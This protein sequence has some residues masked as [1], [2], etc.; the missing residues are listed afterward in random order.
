M[1]DVLYYLDDLRQHY[2]LFHKFFID[3]ILD[4]NMSV[5]IFNVL[6]DWVSWN[7]HYFSLGGHKNLNLAPYFL[8]FLLNDKNF[9]LINDF[10]DFF[11]TDLHFEWYFNDFLNFLDLL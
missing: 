4:I 6:Y 9:D 3:S 5:G 10:F 7:L 2:N 1:M 8:L 11:S